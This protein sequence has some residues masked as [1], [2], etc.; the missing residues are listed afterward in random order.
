MGID[1]LNW[2]LAKDDVP[3]VLKYLSTE[4]VFQRSFHQP[5]LKMNVVIERSFPYLLLRDSELAAAGRGD[6][7]GNYLAVEEPT[8]HCCHGMVDFGL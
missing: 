3:Q 8:P 5:L 1:I 7:L 4:G 6:N 2:V